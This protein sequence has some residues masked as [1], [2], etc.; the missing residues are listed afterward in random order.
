MHDDTDPVHKINKYGNAIKLLD[1]AF[2]QI[3]VFAVCLAWARLR[4][5]LLVYFYTDSLFVSVSACNFVARQE[6]SCQI[7]QYN[8]ILPTEW[9]DWC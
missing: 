3:D 7:T 2:R 9:A 1:A 5:I 6:M 8:A 4:F